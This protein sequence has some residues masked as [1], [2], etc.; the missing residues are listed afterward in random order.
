M[1]TQHPTEMTLKDVVNLE[2]AKD[3]PLIPGSARSVGY[4][5]MLEERRTL[6]V[7]QAESFEKFLNLYSNQ[8]VS[9]HHISIKLQLYLQLIDNTR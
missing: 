1:A 5:A 8:Q 6:P 2:N 3:N 9:Q 4:F 7:M